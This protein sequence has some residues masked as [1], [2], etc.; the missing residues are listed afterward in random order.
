MT[1]EVKKQKKS[2]QK[3]VPR[4]KNS[5]LAAVSESSNGHST[6]SAKHVTNTI[7]SDKQISSRKL[8]SSNLNS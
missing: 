7:S 2:T 6:N 5:M 3:K 4:I 1:Q 8:N